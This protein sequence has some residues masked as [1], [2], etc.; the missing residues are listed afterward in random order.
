VKDNEQVSAFFQSD[1]NHKQL[2]QFSN[3]SHEAIYD[4]GEDTDGEIEGKTSKK[5][6]IGRNE[7][8]DLLPAHVRLGKIL[9]VVRIRAAP[10]S[11]PL[12]TLSKV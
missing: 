4:D 7:Q 12:P 2:L 1:S 10:S 11:L 3:S 8:H 6:K 9:V 5:Q